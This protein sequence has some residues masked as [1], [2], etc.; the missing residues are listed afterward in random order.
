MKSI[1]GKLIL[2]TAIG[3]MAGMNAARADNTITFNIKNSTGYNL[4]RDAANSSC[5]PVGSCTTPG[6]I[7]NGTTG[8]VQHS[9]TDTTYLRTISNRYFYYGS[10]GKRSCQIYATAE[11]PSSLSPG[12]GCK[13]S[14]FDPKSSAR[15]GNGT[16]P[17]CGT[18][19]ITSRDDATCTYVVDVTITD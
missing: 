5:S 3:V 16:S 1:I 9:T 12:P 14:A 19:V 18:A 10:S 4:I 8:V 6:V 11:G 2:V 15:D 7:D 17:K 13:P